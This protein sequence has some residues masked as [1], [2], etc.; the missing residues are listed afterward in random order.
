MIQVMGLMIMTIKI[1]MRR[2]KRNKK[3]NFSKKYLTIGK[4]IKDLK[5]KN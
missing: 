1:Q 5:M 4:M 3:K 2:T